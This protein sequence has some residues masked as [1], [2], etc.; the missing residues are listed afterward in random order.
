MGVYVSK[1][2]DCWVWINELISPS[3]P[4]PVIE[5]NRDKETGSGIEDRN[6]MG[7]F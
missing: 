4:S 1:F 2:H 3:R 7:K 5:S 6:K